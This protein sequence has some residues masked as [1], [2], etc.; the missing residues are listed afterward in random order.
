MYYGYLFYNKKEKSNI[1][2]DLL[3]LGCILRG[4]VQGYD[5]VLVLFCPKKRKRFV[6]RFLN[7]DAIFP[8]S[9]G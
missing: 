2:P 7:K 1:L 6:A 5:N 4:H 9:W 8:T 3:R